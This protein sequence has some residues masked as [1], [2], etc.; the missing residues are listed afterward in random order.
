[1]EFEQ[2]DVV[3]ESLTREL[4]TIIRNRKTPRIEFIQ[5]AD[6]LMN[7]LVEWGLS[8]LPNKEEIVETP[9]GEYLGVTSTK[10]ICAVSI[11]RS[12]D[13]LLEAVRR[14]LPSV[15]VGKILIQRDESTES[16]EAKLIYS[17]LPKHIFTQWV[18]LC[19]PLLAT[20]GSAIKA[21]KQLIDNEVDEDRIYF[22]NL[23]AAPQGLRR[24]L[25]EF[26]K[27]KIITAAIDVGLNND[28]YVVPGV[29]DFG[30][31]YYDTT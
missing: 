10:N 8:R 30:D 6:R 16:K 4:F 5:H 11:V 23:I 9:C 20:G 2:V 15:S 22:L 28:K 13:I 25:K 1:M 14:A 31:I 29:G 21:I 26:P 27:I 19:D 18:L 7:I 12:G 3:D 17:K 24:I